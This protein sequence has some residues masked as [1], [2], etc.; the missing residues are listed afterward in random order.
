MSKRKKEKKEKSKGEQ[1]RPFHV[2]FSH[3]IFHFL[4]GIAKLLE[5][6]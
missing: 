4:L 6:S 1:N 2:R 3:F 5:Y